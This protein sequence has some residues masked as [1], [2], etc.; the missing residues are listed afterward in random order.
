MDIANGKLTYTADTMQWDGYDTFYAFGTSNNSS[1]TGEEANGVYDNVWSKISVLPANNVY[2]EDTFVRQDSDG[3]RVGIVYTGEFKTVTEGDNTEK[4]ES[5]ENETNSNHGWIDALDGELTDTDG[6]ATGA[7]VSSDTKATATFTFKGSG[8]D[9]Y[10]RTSPT[11]G[12]ILVTIKGTTEEGT[13]VSKAKVIDT[14]SYSGDYYQVP[15]CTFDSNDGLAYGTYTVTINVTTAAASENRFTYYLDGIRVYN[16]LSHE[17]EDADTTI[18]D[19]YGDEIHSY[20][21]EIRDDLIDQASGTLT[22]GAVFID[23][24]DDAT[25]VP[26]A[27][28][29]TYEDYGP[30]NEVYLK[31]NQ[32][33]VM[34]VTYTE[35]VKY[36]VGMKLLNGGAAS[37]VTA[38]VMQA[39]GNKASIVIDHSGDMYYEVTPVADTNGNYTIT[40]Q[41]MSEDKVP[42]LSL[43]KLKVTN[44][45]KTAATPVS[46][47]MDISTDDAL[48]VATMAYSAP[49][50]DSDIS[51]EPETPETDDSTEDGTVEGDDGTEDD[52]TED[53]TV[54]D[55]DV[56]E[57]D[58]TGDNTEEEP[59]VEIENPEEDVEDSMTEEQKKLE[60]LYNLAQKLFDI[61]NKWFA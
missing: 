20:F 24:I 1:V 18:Q 38:G 7:T 22:G 43:T 58:T 27:V 26:S 33:I 30:K 10:S 16:P 19:A 21:E 36:Y 35:G 31:T 39:D 11:S 41:N 50:V 4:P 49:V 12:T 47:M 32:M 13:S 57:D 55:D 61:F 54:E 45:P 23:K 53:G 48:A 14:V 40:I 5:A 37:S 25:G 56:T 42:L 34:N 46:F 17:Q 60:E 3:G 15:T 9:I 29:G 51:A 52:T 8:V 59:E 44:V 2:Y 28:V 6:T